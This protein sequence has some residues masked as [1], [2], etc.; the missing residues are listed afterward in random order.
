MT[1]NQKRQLATDL[2][3]ALGTEAAMANMKNTFSKEKTTTNPS[4]VYKPLQGLSATEI[5]D[6]AEENRQK[7]KK[8]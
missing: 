2:A 1:D 3:D 8:R 4:D 6:R 7:R 5:H